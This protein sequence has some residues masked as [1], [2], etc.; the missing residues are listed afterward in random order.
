MSKTTQSYD[1]GSTST[2]DHEMPAGAK[3]LH[4]GVDGTGRLCVWMEQDDEQLDREVQTFAV[5]NTSNPI[6]DDWSFCASVPVSKL[7]LHVYRLDDINVLPASIAEM[8][9]LDPEE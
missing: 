3:F 1:L 2:S 9:D 5:F 7:M 8:D 6:P 4:A